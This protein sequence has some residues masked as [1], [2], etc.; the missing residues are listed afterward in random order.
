MPQTL[1]FPES[2]AL[3]SRG[4][5]PQIAFWGKMKGFCRAKF[6]AKFAFWR[7]AVQGEVFGEVW[8]DVFGGKLC[9]AILAKIRE[10]IMTRFCWAAVSNTA[11]ATFITPEN[12]V[13][14][15]NFEY[16]KARSN[17]L[18]GYSLLRLTFSLALII[19]GSSASCYVQ[20]QQ[21]GGFGVKTT[22]RGLMAIHFSGDISKLPQVIV[23]R[24][25]PRTLAKI[26]N[27]KRNSLKMSLFP[28]NLESI[29]SLKANEKII[30]RE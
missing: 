21:L 3:P 19:A 30:L 5:G 15:K 28:A 26:T 18:C 10:K 1:N 14:N 23:A 2:P 8:G 29:K 20:T 13:F 11:V 27:S 12:N 7:E 25:C 9:T 17:L 22:P 4:A 24:E 16:H 6:W